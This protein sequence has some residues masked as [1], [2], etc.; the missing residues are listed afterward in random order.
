MRDKILIVEDEQDIVNLISNRLDEKQY[1]ITVALNGQKALD[2]IR[3]QEFDL[4]SLD[5]MLPEVDGL[6]IC[7]ELRE[8][9]KNTLIIVVSA[10]DLNE[11]KEKAYNLGADDYISKPFPPK[12][13][14]LKMAS[15][16][17][18]RF[19]MLHS[20]MKFKKVVQHNVA[21]QRFFINNKHLL[22]TPSEYMIFETLFNNP[23]KIF[24][25]DELSQILYNEDLGSI[26]RDGIRTHIYTLRKKISILTDIE[27][28]RTVRGTG[29]TL[30][31]N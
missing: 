20:N 17:Q 18:R 14:A 11:S 25:K 22:L 1:D 2:L 7:K 31:E 8:K 10:L 16:L 28:V 26:D 23:I 24:S 13:L 12:L 3:I 4:V 21:L 5:I 9:N 29:F 15:L 30:Y 27:I 6:T 19:E